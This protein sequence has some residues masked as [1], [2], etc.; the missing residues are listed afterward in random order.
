VEVKRHHWRKKFGY[1]R[2]KSVKSRNDPPLP[3]DELITGRRGFLFAR[4]V[5]AV[6]VVVVAALL[7][8][9][10]VPVR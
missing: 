9:L 4:K 2:I 7:T 5:R 8:M 1:G 10:V 3:G 6:Q